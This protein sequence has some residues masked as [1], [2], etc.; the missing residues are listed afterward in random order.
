MNNS[1]CSLFFNEIYS[2]NT[3][4]YNVCCLGASDNHLEKKFKT[5]DVTPF[6]FFLSEEMDEIRDK[7]LKG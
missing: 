1:Y 3:G 6:E 5:K 2:E 7:A 4:S